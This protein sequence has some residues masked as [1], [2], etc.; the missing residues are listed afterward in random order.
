MLSLDHNLCT[1]ICL[2]FIREEGEKISFVLLK[3][4][5]LDRNCLHWYVEQLGCTKLYLQSLAGNDTITSICWTS[6]LNN[7]GKKYFFALFLSIKSLKTLNLFYDMKTL[8]AQ[9]AAKFQLVTRWK[10]LRGEKVNET[11][12]FFTPKNLR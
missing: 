12:I 5:L 7:K 11:A 8:L 9:E 3:L 4:C 1:Y 10:Q 6:N 2:E